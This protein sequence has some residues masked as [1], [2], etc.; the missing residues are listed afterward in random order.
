MA[1]TPAHEQIETLRI[2]V[3]YPNGQHHAPPRSPHWPA[4]ERTVLHLHPFCACCGPNKHDKGLQV[5]HIFPFHMAIALGRPD[6][7]LDPRNL[8]VLC[9]TE[10]ND[11]EANH[12]LAIGHMGNFKSPGNIHVA[13]DVSV[14]AGMTAA[15]IEADPRWLAR[16]ATMMPDLDKMTDDQKAA[17]KALMDATVPVQAQAA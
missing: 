7:E 3:E 11:P 17:F 1:D 10:H 4:V 16:K 2:D 13:D 5:H 6:L 12:H 14:F 9:E 15:E 8:I